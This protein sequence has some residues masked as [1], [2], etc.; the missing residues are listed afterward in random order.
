MTTGY[1]RLVSEFRM[2]KWKPKT[3]LLLI[4]TIRLILFESDL[5]SPNADVQTQTGFL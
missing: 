1:P 3:V 4:L 5:R 2:R